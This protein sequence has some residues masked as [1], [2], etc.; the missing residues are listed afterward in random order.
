ML[1]LQ[2]R[3]L[4][5]SLSDCA[6]PG[7]HVTRSLLTC[8]YR[9]GEEFKTMPTPFA[10]TIRSVRAD[11]ARS[12]LLVLPLVAV[13]A[14]AWAGWLLR[15]QI[16]MYA[17]SDAARLETTAASEP[18]QS[19][20][21]G[22][23]SANHITL[24]RA[25]NR[26]DVLVELDVNIERLQM[27]EERTQSASLTAE[28]GVLQSEIAAERRTMQQEQKATAI[29]IQA[30]QVR[31]REAQ[32][33]SEYAH[34]DADNKSQL[35][36]EGLL[37]PLEA[38][39]ARTEVEKQDAE[40]AALKLV[41][42]Q[43]QQEAL[44]H[45]AERNSRIEALKREATRLSGMAEKEGATLYRLQSEMQLRQIVAA[46]DGTIG[47]AANLRPGVVISAGER[48]GAI[49]PSGSLRVVAQFS[50]TVALGRVHRGQ[51]ARLR[52]D[53]FPWTQYGMLSA[54]VSR[55]A[56]EV[57]DGKVR[58]ELDPLTGTRVPLQYGLT[59]LAEV[60][61]ERI[62]PVALLLRTG[63]RLIAQTDSS[64]GRTPGGE[65]KP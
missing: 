9:V 25:V 55:V 43:Q 13:L 48:L 3:W 38:L 27:L 32:A 39:H 8:R 60:E 29:A 17:V 12:L 47:E 20:Y 11:R 44:T 26:G 24:G 36:K 7:R 42:S 30:S 10:R 41:I 18:I 4:W 40:L 50:P 62:T 56:D 16:S 1:R 52:F 22:R 58:V 63:G 23:I 53:A 54:T 46:A 21:A 5:P 34:M 15:A 19:L 59:G 65:T 6:P 2:W 35:S 49:I 45:S 14:A 37:P 64:S 57:R 61:T 31:L 28:L 51:H 33:T